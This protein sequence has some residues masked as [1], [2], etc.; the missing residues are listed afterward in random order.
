MSAAY[1]MAQDNARSLT[2]LAGPGV[3]DSFPLHLDGISYDAVVTYY[4]S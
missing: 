2:Q 1:T 4:L 3:L